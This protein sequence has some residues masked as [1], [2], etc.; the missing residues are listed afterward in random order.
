MNVFR[1]L[2]FRANQRCWFALK[3]LCWSGLG[4]GLFSGKTKTALAAWL[5][6]ALLAGA[7]A[8]QAQRKEQFDLHKKGVDAW[9]AGKVD[10][11]ERL[12]RQAVGLLDKEQ[13]SAYGLINKKDYTPHYYLG[14]ILARK[15]DCRG[16]L[17]EFGKSESFGVI[18]KTPLWG[19]LERR[20]GL[21]ETTVAQVDAASAGAR[22]SLAA[23]RKAVDSA[24]AFASKRELASFW[25]EGSPTWRTLLDDAE[26]KLSSAE[27]T[28][29][30]VDPDNE[31]DAWQQA[32]ALAVEAGSRASA[33]ENAARQKLSDLSQAANQALGSLDEVETGAQEL[34]RAITPLAPYPKALGAQ[35]SIVQGLIA[36]VSRLRENRDSAGVPAL[37]EQ[38]GKE[39]RTLRSLSAMPPT[40]LAD[41]AQAYLQGEMPKAI[42]LLAARAA[43]DDREKFFTALL[44]AAAR[45]HQWVATGE[46][47]DA[48]W[49]QLQ[50]DLRAAAAIQ[51]SPGQPGPGFFSPRFRDL[52]A[53]ANGGSS[54][55]SSP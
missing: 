54:P 25:D 15:K 22:K 14:L 17:V 41:A 21:C 7:G 40:A 36:Q 16:A 31:V 28:V 47:D 33:V 35:V 34:M 12:F 50:N 30:A 38:L 48:L 39:T 37:V 52:W 44:L 51:P 20:R 32:N 1:A 6:L 46:Q 43:K 2:L 11:A 13:A 10:E 55:A 5:A 23:A 45:F 8:A 49:Q 19:D 24:R 9:E 3:Q 18:Q 27:K 53:R 4:T 26:A 29:A 42:G